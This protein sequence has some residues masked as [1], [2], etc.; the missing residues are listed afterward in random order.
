MDISSLVSFRRVHQVNAFDD[1]LVLYPDNDVIYHDRVHLGFDVY[2]FHEIDFLNGD[3]SCFFL[4]FRLG[5]VDFSYPC[6]EISIY[7]DWEHW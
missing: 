1:D 5:N 4:Y 2:I 6:H 3:L 7:Y